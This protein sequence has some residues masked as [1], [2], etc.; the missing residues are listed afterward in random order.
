MTANIADRDLGS[1]VREIKGRLA[2]FEKTLPPGYFL[3]YGG[4]YEDMQEAFLILAAAFALAILLVYMIMASQF[5]H[6]THPFI[7]MFTVPLGIVGVIVGLL[8]TGRTL[9]MAALVG[10]IMLAGIAVNNGIVMIDYINQLIKRGVDKREAILQGATT[11]LRAVTADR[12]DDHPGHPAHGLLPVLGLRVPGAHGRR[13]RLRADR[14]DGPDALRH[15]GHLQ[16]GQ[17]DTVSRKR[18]RRLKSRS[19]RT[20]DTGGFPGG[21]PPFFSGF[22]L[23]EGPDLAVAVELGRRVDVLDRSRPA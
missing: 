11:R 17:Q 10:V 12:P 16:R 6:F 2:G 1:V 13:H 19:A 18:K 21:D 22:V 9:S 23:Q 20:D 8:V 7:I 5:E 4:S 14:D 3:E 15:T